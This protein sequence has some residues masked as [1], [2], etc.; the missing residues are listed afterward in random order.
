MKNLLW[1]CVDQL[2]ADIAYHERYP[3]V[4]TPHLDQLRSEGITF[5]QTFCNYPVCAPSRASI[6]TG[7]YPS[8]I[9]VTNNRCILPPAERTLGHHLGDN[10]FETVAF[11]KTH[12]QNPGWRRVPEPQISESLG[13]SKWGYFHGQSMLDAAADGN[14]ALEPVLGV[15]EAGTE[16][17]YDFILTRQVDQFLTQHRSDVPVAL[18]VGFHTPHP[19]LYPPTEFSGLYKPDQIE[20]P[21]MPTGA[22]PQMQRSPGREWV[23]TD[24][25]TRRRMIA[26]YLDLVTHVD[27]AIGRLLHVLTHHNMRD[28]TVIVFVSDHG[29]QLGEHDMI[30]KFNNFYEGSLRVP[31]I[32]RFPDQAHGGRRIDQLVELVDLYPTICDSIGVGRPRNLSGHSLISVIENPE[33]EHRPYV[34]CALV[35]KSAHTVTAPWSGQ[36]FAHGQMIRTQRWK[37]AVYSSGE[38]ELYDLEHDTGETTNRFDDPDVVVLKAELLQRL[39]EHLMQ[40]TT[41]PALWGANMFPG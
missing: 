6:Q 13:A 16:N 20:L 38:G 2:R 36:S 30:G 11:G 26:A 41:D 21:A 10:G 18:W 19:P 5:T 17:H 37:L 35:E 25:D 3:F 29:E 8:Q 34:H 23:Q 24:D 31:L 40:H 12:G 27:A 4:Q 7:R 32:I 28:D 39:T 9:G 33:I 14:H 15:F 22:K 1:I